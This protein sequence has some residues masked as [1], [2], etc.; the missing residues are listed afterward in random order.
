MGLG[1]SPVEFLPERASA[2]ALRQAVDGDRGRGLRFVAGIVER[3]D[4]D[5][6]RWRRV[7]RDG[8]IG[9]RAELC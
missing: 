8:E 5:A 7:V 6:D 4:D 3:G 2:E 1:L 9:E